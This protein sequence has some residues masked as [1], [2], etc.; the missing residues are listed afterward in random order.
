MNYASALFCPC[1]FITFVVVL[2]VACWYLFC[3]AGWVDLIHVYANCFATQLSSNKLADI[4][5]CVVHR[6]DDIS[7]ARMV[8]SLITVYIDKIANYMYVFGVLWATI[9]LALLGVFVVTY[10]F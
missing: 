8:L 5:P 3:A 6:C 7:I 1:I 9:C 4:T 2:E 10:G